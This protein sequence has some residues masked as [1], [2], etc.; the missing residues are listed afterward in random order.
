M[1]Q[2]VE[3]GIKLKKMPVLANI[4]NYLKTIEIIFSKY[5]SD[6][7]NLTLYYTSSILLYVFKVM[8]SSIFEI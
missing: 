4:K 2:D 8:R 7:T 5:Y 3:F 1:Y 6:I